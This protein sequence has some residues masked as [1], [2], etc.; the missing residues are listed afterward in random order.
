M[1]ITLVKLF[2]QFRV[3]VVLPQDSG[4]VVYL[5]FNLESVLHSQYNKQ[6]SNGNAMAVKILLA[7][8]SLAFYALI[9]DSGQEICTSLH[10]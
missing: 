3:R 9:R 10:H 4:Q 1:T 5:P 8:Y 7:S 6:H 2:H